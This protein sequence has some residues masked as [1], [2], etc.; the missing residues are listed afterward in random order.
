MSV[1]LKDALARFDHARHKEL[2]DWLS[3]H[4]YKSKQEWPG[5]DEAEAMG[6]DG[7]ES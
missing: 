2:W 3:K 6:K 5:F 4:P 7:H 1:T